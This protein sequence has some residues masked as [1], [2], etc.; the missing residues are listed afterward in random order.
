MHLIGPKGS[1][2]I[3]SFDPAQYCWSGHGTLRIWFITSQRTLAI[4]EQP[5]ASLKKSQRKEHT[6]IHRL[7][8]F[9]SIGRLALLMSLSLAM[10]GCDG[11]TETA[12]TNADDSFRDGG[13]VGDDDDGSPLVD[14]GDNDGDGDGG[15]LHDAGIGEDAGAPEPEPPP[16]DPQTL[17][18]TQHKTDDNVHPNGDE[19]M[20]VWLMNRARQD[21]EAEG[22][23]LAE[24]DE[25]DIAFGRGYFGVNT[26]DLKADFALLDPKPPAA[27]DARLYEASRL[28]SEDLIARDAQDH[29]GQFDRVYAS[30][31]NSGGGRVSVFAYGDSALNVHGALNIDWGFT[32]TGV[33]DPPGHRYAIMG[34]PIGNNPLSNVG[35]AMVTETDPLTDV[36]PYVFSGA[37]I[38]GGSGEHN[39]F[40][41]G[42]VWSDLNNN[43]RYDPGEGLSNVT[44][45]TDLGD[46][47]A[48]TGEAGGYAI[49]ITAP[50]TYTVT[51]SC[52][53]LE[54]HAIASV[55]VDSESVLVDHMAP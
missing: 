20:L 8:V 1:P 36:G 44:V 52:G 45:A 2:F 38:S 24:T 28:H 27:F 13:L 15:Q 34:V 55:D 5:T 30:G 42:T 31:F 17:E 37:Y 50:G 25:S 23:W 9:G 16:C 26:E 51:F 47:H 18:W 35:F 33:Q 48:I 22:I 19:Q 39:R 3:D 7:Y 10:I 4:I 43:E 32:E 12:D 11:L 46:Y 40:I 54:D 53:D 6:L 14:G 41:V 29:D 49:P 21:P